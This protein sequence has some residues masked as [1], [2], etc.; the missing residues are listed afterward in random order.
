MESG[1]TRTHYV[2]NS[3]WDRLWTCRETDCRMNDTHTH[4][5]VY[6]YIYNYNI[7]IYTRGLEL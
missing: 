2:E 1:S 4:T 7:Y 5:Y 6:A 3:L